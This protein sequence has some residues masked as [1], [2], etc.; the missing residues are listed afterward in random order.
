MAADLD[1]EIEGEMRREIA[2]VQPQPQPQPPPP[3]AQSLQ[4]QPQ[5]QPQP[6]KQRAAA[7]AELEAR[8]MARLR[9]FVDCCELLQEG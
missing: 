1:E 3:P 5:P 2:E 8:N 4:P 6:P 9:G 7:A